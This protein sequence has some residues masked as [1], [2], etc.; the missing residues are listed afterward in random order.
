MNYEIMKN[1]PSIDME[2]YE[3]ALKD[4]NPYRKFMNVLF[5]LT[6][7]GR[8]SIETLKENFTLEEINSYYHNYVQLNRR[9]KY[10]Y[11]DAHSMI[12]YEIEEYKERN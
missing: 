11:E 7:K 5:E 10:T 12:K 4:N 1:D 3:K 6:Q 8:I 2:L 9:V